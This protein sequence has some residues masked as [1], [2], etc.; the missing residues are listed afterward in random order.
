MKLRNLNIMKKFVF[1][2]K[3]GVWKKIRHNRARCVFGTTEVVG[4]ECDLDPDADVFVLDDKP[5]PRVIDN[6]VTVVFQDAD[7]N[8][9]KEM[10]DTPWDKASAIIQVDIVSVRLPR[11]RKASLFVI[12]DVG[13]DL[14]SG[15]L[16]IEVREE[17]RSDA[18]SPE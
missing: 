7:E 6:T 4:T 17:Q 12:Q 10:P 18:V 3:A 1:N 13:V 5:K 15:K 16:L 14:D 8:I 9:L 11:K 2:D